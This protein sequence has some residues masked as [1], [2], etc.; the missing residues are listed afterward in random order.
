MIDAKQAQ[1]LAQAHVGLESSVVLLDESPAGLYRIE[2]EDKFYFAVHRPRQ[3]R[4]GGDEIA[5]VD[6]ATGAVTSSYAGE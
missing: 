6:R 3:L 4:V 1:A 2:S 5:I